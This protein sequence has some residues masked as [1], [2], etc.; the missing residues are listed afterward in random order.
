MDK[1][2]KAGK[3][4]DARTADL[5]R[6]TQE[7]IQA[8]TSAGLGSEG[9]GDA[10]GNEATLSGDMVTVTIDG[11]TRT[12]KDSPALRKWLADKGISIR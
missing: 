10:G 11:Q 8:A 4:V 3:P 12:V 9:E 5:L 1:D 2:K 7:K 6:M